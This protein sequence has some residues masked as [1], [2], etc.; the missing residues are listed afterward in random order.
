VGGKRK[1][2]K[3]EGTDR[4]KKEL[5]VEKGRSSK[6]NITNS[7]GDSLTRKNT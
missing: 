3:K 7:K 4:K 1:K 5:E 2:E 6:I